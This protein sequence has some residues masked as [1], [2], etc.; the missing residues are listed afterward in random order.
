MHDS[1]L[2]FPYLFKSFTAKYQVRD[3]VHRMFCI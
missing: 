1:T 2:I 3:K